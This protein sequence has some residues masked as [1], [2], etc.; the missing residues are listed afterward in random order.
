MNKELLKSC[1]IKKRYDRIRKDQGIKAAEAWLQMLTN[2][3]QK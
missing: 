3:I 1:H 2:T